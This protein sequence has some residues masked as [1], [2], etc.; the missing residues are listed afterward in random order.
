[1]LF[2]WDTQE[3]NHSAQEFNYSGCKYFISFHTKLD[4]PHK[5]D[6]I[7]HVSS[8]MPKSLAS[9]ECL[10]TVSGCK[11]FVLHHQAKAYLRW[12][13]VN[14]VFS[15]L[16][17]TALHLI[18]LNYVSFFYNALHYIQ[19]ALHCRVCNPL[20]CILLHCKVLLQCST[21]F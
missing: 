9:F 16:K 10:I 20:H 14:F 17:C 12:T 2:F 18:S 7:M 3:F 21:T 13:A 1:M 11:Y 4:L 6:I 8:V 19:F 5:P 15:Q